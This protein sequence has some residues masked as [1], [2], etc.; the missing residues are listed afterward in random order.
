MKNKILKIILVIICL[1]IILI[2][3]MYLIDRNRMRN[4][5][6]VI[7]STWGYSYTA[8]LKSKDQDG[9][10]FIGTV[11][12]EKEK[13][14]I[15]RPNKDEIEYKSS[16]KISIGKNGD[17]KYGIGKKVLVKH[18]GEIMETYPARINVI[19]IELLD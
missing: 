2:L 5:Q 6:E 3:T 10:L 13:Y 8:P 4:N 18:T 1:S 15:V 9:T 12:E 14:I 16:D 11:I 19:S 7:F 17:I